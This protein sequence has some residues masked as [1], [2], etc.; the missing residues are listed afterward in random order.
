MPLMAD[1][2]VPWWRRPHNLLVVVVAVAVIAI[3][4]IITLR[5]AMGGRSDKTATAET[6]PLV[7]AKAPGRSA[8][9]SLV[10][11]TG[12]IVAR[13]DM[14]IGVEG[15]GGRIVAVLAESG[16][17]VRKGQVLAKLEPTVIAAQVASLH[18]A[19]EQTR[20]EAVLAEADF[21]R[22]SAVVDSVGA[23]SREELDKRRSTVATTAARVKAAEAQL[24]E[25][26]AR[27]GRTDIRAPDE[28]IVLTRSAEVGQTAVAGGAALFRLA[29][30]G[31]IEMR[32]QA[33]EQDLP[34]I[35]LGQRVVVYLTGVATPFEGKVRLVSAVIDPM[36]RLGEVRVSLPP[37]PVLR[38]GAFARGE[39]SI[40]TES[41]PI[42]PQTAVLTDGTNN[43]VYVVGKDGRVVRRPVKV[44]GT[45]PGGIVIGDGLTGS[46][47]VVTSAGAFLHEGERVN[48]V[49]TRG[50]P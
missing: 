27:L 1:P 36:M 2:D 26:E 11:F 19:L 33:S 35:Q 22:A 4:V 37:S 43:F 40:G 24:A 5:M 14:P 44:A 34:H 20:A 6:V 18:A 16:D 13:Y 47:L 50:A 38:P 29:R 15:E 49:S 8:I 46:E 45:Q 41:R 39:V 12:G 32:A 21:R 42:V 10:N 3:V 9:N 48:L 31:E 23:L 7:T 17:H 30:G 25:A 28:G